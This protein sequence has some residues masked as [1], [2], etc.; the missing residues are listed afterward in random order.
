MLYENRHRDGTFHE[1]PFYIYSLYQMNKYKRGI[2]LCN[3]K[4]F[5]YKN[6]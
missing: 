3:T 4:D 1:I 5:M 6:E 2:Y